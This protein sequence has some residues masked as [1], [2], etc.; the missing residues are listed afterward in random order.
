MHNFVMLADALFGADP[1]KVDN[2][3]MFLSEHSMWVFAIILFFMMFIVPDI[4]Y[5]FHSWLMK[6]K[7]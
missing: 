7:K 5:T 4:W 2:F 3:W 1:V 6:D